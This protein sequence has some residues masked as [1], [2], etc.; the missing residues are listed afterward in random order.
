MTT[1]TQPDP[2]ESIAA[3]LHDAWADEQKFHGRVFGPDRTPQTHPHL[4]PWGELDEASRNQDRFIAACLLQKWLLGQVDEGDLPAAI[5]DSW[6]DWSRIN[7][8]NH[9]HAQPFAIAHGDNAG[10]HARQAAYVVRI[11]NQLHL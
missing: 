7:S 10:E 9:P 6:V 4:V 2:L 8:E 1:T 3:A 5:H 11:L